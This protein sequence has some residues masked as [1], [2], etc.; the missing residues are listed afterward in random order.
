[1]RTQQSG[2]S[3]RRRR[4][5]SPS[6][7]CSRQP[8]CRDNQRHAD[9]QADPTRSATVGT[10]KPTLTASTTGHEQD[11]L[12]HQRPPPTTPPR[13]AAGP[14]HG[15]RTRPDLPRLPPPAQHRSGP[16][17]P[18]RRPQPR[19]PPRPLRPVPPPQDSKRSSRRPPPA[20]PPPTRRSAP[21]EVQPKSGPGVG[22]HP[23]APRRAPNATPVPRARRLAPRPRPTPPGWGKPAREAMAAPHGHRP[24]PWVLTRPFGVQRG[25][26]PRRGPRSPLAAGR[27]RR[28]PSLTTW[29]GS[30]T[31]PVSGRVSRSAWA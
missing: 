30:R 19:Q 25:E 12:G 28:V 8:S 26:G 20:T 9:E 24:R 6:Y 10:R 7:C 17:D 18:R 23:G 5:P 4:P 16:Q 22:E 3:R 14:H 11:G 13:L 27:R 29:K 21:G 1:M 15:P 2:R 31:C